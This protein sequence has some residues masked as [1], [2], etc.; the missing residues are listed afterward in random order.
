MTTQQSAVAEPGIAQRAYAIGVRLMGLAVLVQFLLAGLGIFVDN[1]FLSTWHAT[2][3]AAAVAALS[4]ICVVIGL[5][6]RLPGRTVWLTASVLGLVIVQSL[7]LVPW[8]MGAAGPVRAVSA[9]HV[10]NALLIAWVSLRLI[11]KS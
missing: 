9:L 4:L 1:Q 11:Q 10:L 6:A 2:A 3:G 5:L 8:H 7:L